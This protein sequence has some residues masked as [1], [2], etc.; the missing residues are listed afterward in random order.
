MLDTSITTE[1]TPTKGH[2]W[3][4]SPLVGESVK[5]GEL[6]LSGAPVTSRRADFSDSGG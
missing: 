5:S 3:L 2:R 1:A 6:E 4:L